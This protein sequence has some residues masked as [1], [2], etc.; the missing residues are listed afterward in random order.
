MTHSAQAFYQRQAARANVI[1]FACWLPFGLA[2]IVAGVWVAT[3]LGEAVMIPVGAWFALLGC[4]FLEMYGTVWW[5]RRQLHWLAT[6]EKSAATEPYSAGQLNDLRVEWQPWR[7]PVPTGIVGDVAL[8][9]PVVRA[10]NAT[11]WWL[12]AA[13]VLCGIAAVILAF[14]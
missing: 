10:V 1:F 6:D 3:Q 4:Y 7:M 8:K 11:S 13:G 5:Y 9:M 14:E 12:I 2:L